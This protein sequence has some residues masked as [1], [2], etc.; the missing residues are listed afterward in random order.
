MISQQLYSEAIELSH[1]KLDVAAV[2]RALEART[3]SVTRAGRALGSR[4]SG[5]RVVVEE[6]LDHGDEPA[7]ASEHHCL[8]VGE[9]QDREPRVRQ[10]LGHLDRVLGPDD[11][12]V[13]D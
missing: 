12:R 4:R 7:S 1:D 6:R 11:V 9:R 3:P 13:A 8:V 5:S 2:V 10:E